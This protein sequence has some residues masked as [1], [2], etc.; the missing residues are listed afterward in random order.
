M[1]EDRLDLAVRVG[2]I[3]D[4][5]LMLRKLAS[6]CTSHLSPGKQKLGSSRTLEAPGKRDVMT[7]GA[8]RQGQQ[9]EQTRSR[10]KPL[11]ATWCFPTLPDKIGDVTVR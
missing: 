1:I 3:T 5:S 2:D 10:D 8:S 11:A 9:V 7:A 6:A 4:A